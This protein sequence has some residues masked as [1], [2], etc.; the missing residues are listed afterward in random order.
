MNDS[1]E[2]HEWKTS[3]GWI[4]LFALSGSLFL[5][6]FVLMLIPEVPRH[7]DFGT[8]PFTPA[9]SVYSTNNPEKHPD[10]K[11][12]MQLPGKYIQEDN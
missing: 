9:E 5:L 10:G 6:M 3:S 2:H 1:E 7:W 4:F 12:R 8:V 11:T